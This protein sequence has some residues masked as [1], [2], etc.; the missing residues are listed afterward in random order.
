MSTVRFW[1]EFAS[2]YSY[3]A[4]MRVEEQARAWEVPITWQPFLLGPIF[5][6]QGWSDSPFNLNP[7]RGRSMWRDVERTAETYGLPFRKP[8]QF[9][10]NSVLAARVACAGLGTAWL[11]TYARA[12]YRANFEQDLDIADREVVAEALRAAGQD[13]EATLAAAVAPENK[14][15]LREATDRAWNLGICGAPTFEVRGELFWGNDRMEQAFAWYGRLPI[16]CD[17]LALDA[18]DQA[19]RA[20]LADKMR[21][22]TA[23]VQPL[24][25][26]LALRVSAQ[27]MPR[28]EVEELMA[29]ERRC[30]PFLSFEARDS[31]AD[32]IIEI[33]GCPDAQAF[34]TAQFR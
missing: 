16:A 2:T 33:T 30:C 28:V 6:H 23:E 25:N 13:A 24:P 1:F 11:P 4:A 17:L 15:K 29:L 5:A 14:G 8:S 26:G 10:R 32:V 12:V 7:A 34:L 18:G 31:G 21:A 19:R 9:P 3:L 20:A 22:G 27:A